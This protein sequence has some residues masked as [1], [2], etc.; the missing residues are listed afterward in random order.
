LPYFPTL[1]GKSESKTKQKHN[2]QKQNKILLFHFVFVLHGANM[3]YY[4]EPV[5]QKKNVKKQNFP[6]MRSTEIY[7]IVVRENNS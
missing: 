7:D 2:R 5:G 1:R 6:V 4:K 3:M